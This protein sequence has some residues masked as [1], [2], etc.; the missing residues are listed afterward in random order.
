MGA[1]RFSA[2]MVGISEN[3][4]NSSTSAWQTSD[5]GAVNHP[6]QHM[7]GIPHRPSPQL[8]FGRAGE[9]SPQPRHLGVP[10]SKLPGTRRG[11]AEDQGPSARPGASS[12]FGCV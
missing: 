11:L 3:R 4:A 12:V 1:H 8:D 6:P 5:H 10:T 9:R 2:L 7:G